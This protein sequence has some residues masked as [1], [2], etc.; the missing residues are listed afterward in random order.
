VSILDV[1]EDE[2]RNSV[3][4]CLEEGA[5]KSKMKVQKNPQRMTTMIEKQVIIEKEDVG[6]HYQS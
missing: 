3:F 4:N 2:I 6:S 1:P 5:T